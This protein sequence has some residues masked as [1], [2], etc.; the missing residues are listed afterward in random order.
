MKNNKMCSNIGIHYYVGKDLPFGTE[1]CLCRIGTADVTKIKDGWSYWIHTGLVRVGKAAQTLILRLNT[2]LV[3]L[4]STYTIVSLRKFEFKI[5][6]NVSILGVVV[7]VAGHR[8]SGHWLVWVCGVVVIVDG[9]GTSDHWLVWVSGV[10]VSVAGHGTSG[11]WLVWVCGV[12]V[13]VDGHGTSDHRLVWDHDV[14]VS[15][16]SH[17]TTDHRQVRDLI[18]MKTIC[19]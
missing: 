13:I 6:Y 14:V 17:R 1:E 11:H 15:V 2:L 10:V 12:L 7:I 18:L 4:R 19:S 9:H 8:T 16:A 5:G 3:L